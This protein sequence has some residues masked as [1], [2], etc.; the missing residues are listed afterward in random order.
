MVR[1][2]TKPDRAYAL[3][4]HIADDASTR[5]FVERPAVAGQ[6]AEISG[7]EWC[8]LLIGCRA[9]MEPEPAL[10]VVLRGMGLL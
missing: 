10:M 5:F 9:V 3:I 6:V 2:W 4:A 7:S 1:R 8:G